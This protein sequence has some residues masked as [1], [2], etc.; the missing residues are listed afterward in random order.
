MICYR[1]TVSHF[2]PWQQCSWLFDFR[3][4]RTCTEM[5]A[6]VPTAQLGNFLYPQV[7]RHARHKLS[8]QTMAAPF[9]GAAPFRPAHDC[10]NIHGYIDLRSA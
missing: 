3:K 4:I 5:H 8:T 7:L 2:F 9:Q 6:P 1:M 10:I